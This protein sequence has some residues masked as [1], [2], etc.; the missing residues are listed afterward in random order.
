[1]IANYWETRLAE[2]VLRWEQLYVQNHIPITQQEYWLSFT[3]RKISLLVL[4][5]PIFYP[6][7]ELRI[8]RVQLFAVLFD[9]QNAATKWCC[10]FC[11]AILTR[12]LASYRC[13]ERQRDASFPAPPGQDAMVVLHCAHNGCAGGMKSCINRNHA[14]RIHFEQTSWT[15]V[16]NLDR[17][18][19][20]QSG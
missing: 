9:L 2:S 16:H 12:I 3:K 6:S 20:R 8:K 5:R 14:S 19:S 15:A 1:M 13:L 18:L 4:G 11:I 7:D 10:V 17:C